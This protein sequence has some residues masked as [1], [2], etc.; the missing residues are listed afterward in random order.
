MAEFERKPESEIV[1]TRLF[2]PLMSS[3]ARFT[4]EQLPLTIEDDEEVDILDQ[5]IESELEDIYDGPI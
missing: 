3:A 4:V 2:G 5:E 1:L